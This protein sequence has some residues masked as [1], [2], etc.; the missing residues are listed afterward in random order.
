MLIILH[1]T[2]E[3]LKHVKFSDRVRITKYNNTNYDNDM[4]N[5]LLFQNSEIFKENA[6]ND[7]I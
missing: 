2:K 3:I 5:Y 4:E 1:L 7:Y 6:N